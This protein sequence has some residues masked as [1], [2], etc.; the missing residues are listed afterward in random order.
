MSAENTWLWETTLAT[1]RLTADA[2]QIV[3][4]QTAAAQR[5]QHRIDDMGAYVDRI[6]AEHPDLAE[7]MASIQRSAAALARSVAALPQITHAL[8]AWLVA[9]GEVLDETH[10]ANLHSDCTALEDIAAIE[11]SD[12]AD[13]GA[14][15]E[16]IANR[17]RAA[18]A[19]RVAAARARIWGDD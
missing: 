3:A 17:A 14:V 16:D 4:D 8:H 13:G 5:L 10:V 9:A 18:R 6:A 19:A 12:T 15:I 11:V 2:A 1:S 7:T